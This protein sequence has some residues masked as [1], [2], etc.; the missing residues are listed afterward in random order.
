MP[1]SWTPT[2]RL[3]DHAG[4]CR[5]SLDGLACG[6]GDS[7]QDAA[8]D[9]VATVRTMALGIRR[10]GLRVAPDA[11]ALDMR[12]LEFMWEL[13]ELAARGGDIRGRVLGTM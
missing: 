11:G 4:G 1:G 10:G 7:M 2:L 6:Y 12:L 5:L 8:D 13:G 9:L 3:H